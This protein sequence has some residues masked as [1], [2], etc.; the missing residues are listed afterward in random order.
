MG[1]GIWS[2]HYIGMLALKLAVPILYDLPTVLLSLLAAIMGSATAL[3]IVSRKKLTVISV[4][5]GSF[6]MGLAIA[7]MHYLGMAAVRMPAMCHYNP[8]VVGASILIAVVVSAAALLLTFRF[9][10][11]QNEFNLGKISSAV[12]MG[13]AVAAMHYTGMAS[14]CFTSA[15]LVEGVSHAVDVSSLGV[16]GITIVSVFVVAIVAITS[17]LDRRFSAQAMQLA[18]S[19]ERYRLLF[20][21]SLAA[22]PFV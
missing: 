13:L 22:G 16:A 1:F 4:A 5:S 9:R 10:G 12:V 17:L 20:Q 6:V 3:L 11:V 14:V 18:A 8:I 15:P 2:M 19:E 21:R 7:A